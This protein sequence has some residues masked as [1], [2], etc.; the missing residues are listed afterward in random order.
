MKA[1][2]NVRKKHDNCIKATVSPLVPQALKSSAL[3]K[4]E[5]TLPICE[6]PELMER[7]RNRESI[8]RGRIRDPNPKIH[9]IYWTCFRAIHLY[10]PYL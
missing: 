8:E 4:Y 9:C 10:N 6:L 5:S 1:Y 7:G 3:Q 2:M